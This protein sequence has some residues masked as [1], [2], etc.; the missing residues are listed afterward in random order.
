M[1]FSNG[2]SLASFLLFVY[3]EEVN[4]TFII[5]LIGGTRCSAAT[6]ISIASIRSVPNEVELLSFPIMLT[7]CRRVT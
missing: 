6:L 1:D 3:I 4:E 5:C 7:V 2:R